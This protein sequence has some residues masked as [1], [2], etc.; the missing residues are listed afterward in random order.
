MQ[1]QPCEQV[2]RL[3]SGMEN[4][5]PVQWLTG[6]LLARLVSAGCAL[7]FWMNGDVKALQFWFAGLLFSP[8]LTLAMGA[9]SGSNKAFELKRSEAQ[10]KK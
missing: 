9:W 2:K 4:Q 8:S 1:L 6:F 3:E 10:V 5:L 7:R